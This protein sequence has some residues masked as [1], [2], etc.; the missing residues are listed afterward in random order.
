MKQVR[1]VVIVAAA[2]GGAW[3]GARYF[4]PLGTSKDFAIICTAYE[5]G[6]AKIEQA[7]INS[8]QPNEPEIAFEIA[9]AIE[10]GVVNKDVHASVRGISFAS[11]E[12]KYSLLQQ[13]AA[14]LGVKDWECEAARRYME[15]ALPGSN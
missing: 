11:P 15:R 7:E 14:E 3:Y 6:M 9:T 5:K 2:I 13:A 8:R 12:S 10:K 4:L 1:A